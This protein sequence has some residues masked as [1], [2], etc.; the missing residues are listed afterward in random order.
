M[1]NKSAKKIVEKLKE[2]HAR[3]GGRTPEF[4]AIE[5]E[6]YKT[7]SASELR[8]FYKYCRDS[9]GALFHEQACITY[10]LC[11]TDYFSEDMLNHANEEQKKEIFKRAAS[12]SKFNN[13]TVKMFLF[14]PIAYKKEQLMLLKTIIK[15]QDAEKVLIKR[16]IDKKLKDYL[17]IAS[18]KKLKTTKLIDLYLKILNYENCSH[19]LTKFNRNIILNTLTKRKDIAFYTDFLFAKKILSKSEIDKFV[20]S[21]A[22]FGDEMQIQNTIKYKGDYI[23]AKNIQVL[24]DSKSKFDHKFLF[25]K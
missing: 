14:C 16:D 15:N 18:C 22:K 4:T 8:Y 7:A 2:I 19:Y 1:I 25:C 23:G 13:Y 5:T 20:V 9:Q 10:M 21:I 6:F 3:Y 11:K 24:I 12:K 17:I